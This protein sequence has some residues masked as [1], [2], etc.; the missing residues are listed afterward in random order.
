MTT[1]TQTVVATPSLPN[2]QLTIVNNVVNG[3][4]DQI[5][6]DRA[7]RVQW[8][9]VWTDSKGKPR[10]ILVIRSMLYAMAVACVNLVDAT[11]REAFAD[12]F[13]KATQRGLTPMGISRTLRLEAGKEPTVLLEKDV[14]PAT[15]GTKD[16]KGQTNKDTDTDNK[17]TDNKDTDNKDTD[18]TSTID[19]VEYET[20]VMTEAEVY[21]DVKDYAFDMSDKYQKMLLKALVKAHGL[22]VTKGKGK[23]RAVA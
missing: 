3:L 16:T 2:Y 21:K 11:D 5:K 23:G 13:R 1:K 8:A 17:D 12:K 22:P 19:G 10:D 14:S 18:G 9:K 7:G 4:V 15:V 20:H 6:A